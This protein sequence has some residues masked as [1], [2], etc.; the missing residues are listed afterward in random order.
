VRSPV[1]LADFRDFVS[2]LEDNAVKITN[3]NFKGLSPLCDE[4]GFGDFAAA[5]EERM[6]QRDHEIASLQC[7]L[8]R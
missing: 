7:E 4:F 6:Q 1:S 3:R 8:L 2:A 5:L